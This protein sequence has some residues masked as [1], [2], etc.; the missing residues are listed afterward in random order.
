MHPIRVFGKK[1]ESH[2]GHRFE[3]LQRGLHAALGKV[4]GGGMLAAALITAS[5]ISALACTQLYVGRGQTTTGDTYVGRAEDYSSR[6]AKVFGVQQREENPVFDSL[7]NGWGTGFHWTYQGT[8]YRYTYVR[9]LASAWEDPRDAADDAAAAKAYSEAGTNERGVSVS[10]TLTTDM[11]A[12]IRAVDPGVPTGIGEYNL[13]DV[14]LSVA[15]SARDGVKKLGAII[16]EHGSYDNNQIIIAD[17]KETFI[18]SQLSGH[19]WIALK[20]SDDVA[21]VNPN[22]GN[23]QYKVDLNDEDACLHSADIVKLPQEHGLLKTFADGT[24]NIAKTYG[25]EDPG[26]AQWTR[27]AQGRAYFGAALKPGEDYTVGASGAV[28]S[29]ADPELTFTPA[30][31]SDTFTALRALAARGEQVESLNANLNPALYAI[32]NENTV[33]AHV[34]QIRSG[35]S[36]DIATVQWEALSRTE[37]SLYLPSYS[38]LLTSV[39]EE[40]YGDSTT[41][42]DAHQGRGDSVEAALAEEPAKN[43]DY[44]MMDINTL[45]YNN[46]AKMAAGTRGYLDALQKAVIAQQDAVD[47]VMR[48]TPADQRTEL[49]N[50]AFAT[51]TEQAYAKVKALVDEMRAY[52]KAGASGDAF[53][54]SDYDAAA[55]ALKSPLLYGAALVAP[56]ITA[57]PASASYERGAVAAPLSVS[58]EA[59]DGAAGAA[60]SYQWF[61]KGADGSF[62]PVEGATGTTLPVDT[63]KTG[64]ATYRVEVANAAGLKATSDEATVT[65]TE[66]QG[67]KPGSDDGKAPAGTTNDDA[68]D[69]AR[70]GEVDAPAKPKGS[71]KGAMPQTGDYAVAGAAAVAAVGAASLAVGLFRERRRS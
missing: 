60:L 34:Y 23:L 63:S 32:G 11:N 1:G 48:A 39:P 20:M 3:G 36:A 22:I 62:A 71:P 69:D 17:A 2:M 66:P 9:D 18:F 67:G 57:Q 5:P 27:Y 6:Y 45:A 58:A 35:L 37:F 70:G 24:P 54:P 49:A 40:Y 31:K 4:A 43:L 28:A 51:V 56:A 13:A 14:I 52:V 29:V 53:V 55:G 65:V 50:K 38:A 61:K 30:T 12:G 15:D 7:E 42:S 26:S 19:Q 46:R 33:E 59:R 8:S 25:A 44:I 21:S 47:Q 16:D 41:L 68:T 64:S 10:A